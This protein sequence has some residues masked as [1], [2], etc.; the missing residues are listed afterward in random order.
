MIIFTKE[1]IEEIQNINFHDAEISRIICDYDAG[2]LEMPIIMDDTHQY[3]A[4]LNFDNIVYMEVNHKESWGS[5]C[6]ISTLGIENAE[7]E[8]FKVSILLN[9][10]DEIN[11]I[12]A[13]MIYSSSE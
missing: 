4:L 11:V 1:K 13:K 5:G 10:G 6:Y 2:T 9:S 12:A 3:P 8:Y 7:G